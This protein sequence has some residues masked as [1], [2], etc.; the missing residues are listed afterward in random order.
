MP[1]FRSHAREGQLGRPIQTP[2]KAT[3]DY[4][5][6]KQFVGKL[7]E[8]KQS[9]WERDQKFLDAYK[10]KLVKEKNARIAVENAR[11]ESIETEAEKWRRTNG[12]EN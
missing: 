11:R 3:A 5:R 10:E 6:G 4:K 2:D 9:A 1:E 7:K 8:E 12:A